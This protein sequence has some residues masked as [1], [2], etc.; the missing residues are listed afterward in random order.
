MLKNIVMERL[1]ERIRRKREQLHLHLNEL[2][3]KVGVSSSAL[4]Q[5][6]NSKS[7]PSVVTL[8]SIADSL[9]T[10]IGELVGEHESLAS[11]PVVYKDEIKFLSDNGA[12][13]MVYSLSNQDVSK[14]MDTLLIRLDADSTLDGVVTNKLGQ[15]FCHVISGELLVELNNK[16]YNLK[17]GDNL[18]FNARASFTAANATKG[19]AEL[20][21]IQTPSGL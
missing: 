16:P 3:E 12:G 8:K 19:Y 21:W 4:S 7:F 17:C 15:V 18:Y 20:L 1:G 11:Q 5:I 10:S 6:E 13:T 9:H 2:A 14:Q